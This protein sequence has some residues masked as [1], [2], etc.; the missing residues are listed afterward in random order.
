MQLSP[1][2]PHFK[3]QRDMYR[4][5][6][7]LLGTKTTPGCLRNSSLLSPAACRSAVTGDRMLASPYTSC[8]VIWRLGSGVG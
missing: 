1:P 3:E 6:H 7:L 2:R 8:S 5:L 4:S